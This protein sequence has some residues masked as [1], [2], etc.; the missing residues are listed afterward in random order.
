MKRSRAANLGYVERR[1]A[2][3]SVLINSLDSVA[4]VEFGYVQQNYEPSQ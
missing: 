4:A 3:S 1:T 2:F